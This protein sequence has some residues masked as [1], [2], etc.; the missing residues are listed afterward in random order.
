MTLLLR[1]P[2]TK[3]PQT[4]GGAKPGVGGLWFGSTWADRVSGRAISGSQIGQRVTTASGHRAISVTGTAALGRAVLNNNGS[5]RIG[6]RDFTV[7]IRFVLQSTS[8]YAGIG[9]WDTGATPANCDWSLGGNQWA[10]EQIFSVAVGSTAYTATTGAAGTSVGSEYTMVGRRRG[11]T[12]EVIRYNLV[13]GRISG[14]AVTGS[15]TN[16]GITTVNYNSAR[17]LKLGEI[18]LGATYN[19]AFDCIAAAIENRAWTDAEIREYAEAPWLLAAPRRIIIPVSAGAGGGIAVGVA[20]ESD[21]AQALAAV[22]SRAAAAATETDAALALT[23]VVGRSVGQATETDS[24]Q[25]LSALLVG[26]T[27]FAS[28]TDA[29]LALDVGA[30]N[31]VGVAIETDTALAPSARLVAGVGLSAETDTALALT[32]GTAIAV[33]SAIEVDSAFALAALVRSGIGVAVETDAALALAGSGGTASAAEVWSYM[34]SNGK[35]AEETVTEI[36][37]MLTALQAGT[38]VVAANVKKVNDVTLQGT[39]VPGDSMRPA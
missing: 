24:A 13:G 9:R 35:T 8:G 30:S 10:T 12:I 31:Q 5:D 18:D 37:A 36:H 6:G 26:A 34:L 15:T 21:S 33:G 17:S 32:P 7:M 20:T 27:G 38:L 28:E 39:G 4:E 19:S 2:W 16:A 11:T 23:P 22:L 14:S 1:K 25:A 3:Q 29:A